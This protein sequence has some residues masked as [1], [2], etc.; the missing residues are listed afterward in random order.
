MSAENHD[1]SYHLA[2]GNPSAYDLPISIEGY[3]ALDKESL[4][5]QGQPIN[6]SSN[7]VLAGSYTYTTP[8]HPI[9][10]TT[11]T[12]DYLNLHMPEVAPNIRKIMEQCCAEHSGISIEP[13][14][15]GGIPHL[16]GTR[17]SVG[18]IV[19]RV[20]A[21]GSIKAVADYYS[22]DI[23]EK[24]VKEAMSYAQDF[25]ERACDPY[26]VDG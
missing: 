21:L 17:L 1:Q 7:I 22:P 23:T 3:G 2:L 12:V 13:E 26:Q 8:I 4:L 20:R 9:S 15:L 24:Q 25:I 16:E 5:A 14:V 10:I 6:F 11:V 18:Q 19:G